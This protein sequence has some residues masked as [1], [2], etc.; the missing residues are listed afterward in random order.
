MSVQKNTFDASKIR[1]VKDK[2]LS[3]VEAFGGR[4]FNAPPLFYNSLQKGFAKL[5][6]ERS[7]NETSFNMEN[8]DFFGQTKQTANLEKTEVIDLSDIAQANNE[9]ANEKSNFLQHRRSQL[10]TQMRKNAKKNQR[11]ELD[12]NRMQLARINREIEQIENQQ[13]NENYDEKSKIDLHGLQIQ[14][15]RI[16][17]DGFRN[18]D[19]FRK[20]NEVEQN[21]A[22]LLAKNEKK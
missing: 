9:T 7:V 1:L 18:K 2:N 6:A 22:K 3:Q 14:R 5:M 13:L 16:I 19:V 11:Y 10:L 20:I 15:E 12:E 8:D 17:A 4:I 21:I